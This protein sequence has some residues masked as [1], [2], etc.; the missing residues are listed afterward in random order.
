MRPLPLAWMA[1]ASLLLV[2]RRPSAP[3]ISQALMLRW[4]DL[5]AKWPKGGGFTP[6]HASGR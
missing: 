3:R 1:L 5:D 6:F 2:M 4:L